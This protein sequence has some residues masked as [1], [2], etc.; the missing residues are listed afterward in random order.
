MLGDGMRETKDG[1]A[2]GDQPVTISAPPAASVTV[3][4]QNPLPEPSFK[5]RRLLTILVT[6]T[7]LGLQWFLAVKLHDLGQSADLLT[8]AKWSIALNGIVL[9]YYF[10][11]PSAAEL[12]NIIQSANIIKKS[13]NLAD[14]GSKQAHSRPESGQAARFGGSV[15]PDSQIPEAGPGGAPGPPSDDLEE[16]A[17]PRSRT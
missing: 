14:N 13:L 10:I 12:V 8:F 6:I 17:A 5:W 3:D 7:L 15:A 1:E 2:R 4:P 16:D 11:A 9:T